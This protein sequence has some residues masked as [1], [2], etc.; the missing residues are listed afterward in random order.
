ME[1]GFPSCQKVR[2]RD[3][4]PCRSGMEGPCSPFTEPFQCSSCCDSW[5]FSWQL[6]CHGPEYDSQTVS[7]SLSFS[8]FDL[9]GY[10]VV[11]WAG[12][13][14][15]LPGFTLR[16]ERTAS[17]L[18]MQ[19]AIMLTKRSLTM[20]LGSLLRATLP[21]KVN[22]VVSPSSKLSTEHKKTRTSFPVRVKCTLSRF[23]YPRMY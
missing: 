4:R 12:F 10:A 2:E 16:Q 20:L 19:G 17:P 22:H 14:P 8:S 21:S 7:R 18:P 11:S 5:P 6:S 3:C 15:T 23:R 1:E 13:R 9:V